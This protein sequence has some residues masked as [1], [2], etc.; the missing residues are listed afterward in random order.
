M[1]AITSVSTLDMPCTQLGEGDKR[2][3]ALPWC[4]E[5]AAGRRQCAVH[6]LCVRCVHAFSRMHLHAWSSHTHMCV[7]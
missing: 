4:E 3:S 2:V 1:A 5:D 6:E 7:T